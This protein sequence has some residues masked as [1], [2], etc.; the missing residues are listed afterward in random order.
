MIK[1]INKKYNK[2]VISP[3]PGNP[4]DYPIS[5]N[6]YEQYKGKKKTPTRHKEEL[7]YDNVK[8]AVRS[9]K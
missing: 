8:L 6:I 7:K 9:Y 5:S 2:I 3:G 4:K 1:L